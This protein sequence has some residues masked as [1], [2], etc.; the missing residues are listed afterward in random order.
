MSD[1]L[2]YQAATY[3]Q[4]LLAQP[5]APAVADLGAQALRAAYFAQQHQATLIGTQTYPLRMRVGRAQSFVSSTS[6]QRIAEWCSVHLAPHHS[7]IEVEACLV[8]ALVGD[9]RIHL[10]IVVADGTATHTSTATEFV[11][12]PADAEGSIA[13][14]ALVRVSNVL[15]LPATN[16]P[17]SN[18]QVR[19]E[20]YAVLKDD[21]TQ[22][23]PMGT[24]AVT[25]WRVGP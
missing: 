10:R 11:P 15:T 9:T 1:G 19:V 13:G 16:L 12:D 4:P 3:L 7:R 20:M 18:G 14:R 8:V 23:A 17:V 2:I 25:A 6:Y 21:P 5:D 24:A 22:A